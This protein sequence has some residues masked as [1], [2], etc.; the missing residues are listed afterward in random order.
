MRLD[1][2][3]RRKAVRQSPL[4]LVAWILVA[5]GCTVTNEY[6]IESPLLHRA[7]RAKGTVAVSA[8]RTA[9]GRPVWLA[10]DSIEAVVSGKQNGRVTVS[11]TATQRT[12]AAGAA[13]L[14]TGGGMLALGIIL[15]VAAHYSPPQSCAGRGPDS[16]CWIAAGA[17]DEIESDIGHGL[18]GLGL[19]LVIPGAIVFG[20]GRM[21]G[22]PQEIAPGRADW[23]YL[24]NE[25]ASSAPGQSRSGLRVSLFGMRF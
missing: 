21:A 1:V 23:R 11:S 3:L 12:A 22:P 18:I 16:D 2:E 6:A 25:S 13:L 7:L 14:G 15:S 5:A 10:A 8:T 20:V 9:D 4:L 19:A 17:S 24:S